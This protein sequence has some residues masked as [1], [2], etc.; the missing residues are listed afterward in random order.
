MRETLPAAG[1]SSCLAELVLS[2]LSCGCGCGVRGM[3][4]GMEE[5]AAE[6][7]RSDRSEEGEGDRERSGLEHATRCRH[8]T[9]ELGQDRALQSINNQIF[10]FKGEGR[11]R[12]RNHT[13][14]RRLTSN[15]N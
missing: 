14:E 15:V 1:L 7:G 3:T 10:A 5:A 12:S 9:V 2:L 4:E 8:K 6:G 13:Q 11:G